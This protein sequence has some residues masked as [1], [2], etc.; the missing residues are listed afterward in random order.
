M[1]DSA[2]TGKDGDVVEGY[3]TYKTV[4]A[5]INSVSED[6]AESKVIFIKNGKY[7]E[8]V[9]VMVPNV[10]LLGEDA[11]KTHIY[12]SAAVAEKQQQVCGIEMLCMLILRQ[13]DL[14]RRILQ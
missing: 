5:A 12:Y 1:V 14:Q 9:T 2:F 10:S 4:Q 6:N 7:N 11:Q 3:A 13:M 8:R